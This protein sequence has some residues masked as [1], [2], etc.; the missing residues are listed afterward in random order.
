MQLDNDSPWAAALVPGWGVN[1]QMQMTC[2]VKMVF[3]W[4]E[5]GDLSPRPAEQHDICYQDVYANDD[6]ETGSIVQ[7]SDTSPFKEGF[8]CFLMRQ[9]G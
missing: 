5:H 4:D 6:P 3:Q 8:E 7:A 1:H 9:S 2:L